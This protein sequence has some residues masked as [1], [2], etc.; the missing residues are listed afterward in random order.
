[1]TMVNPSRSERGAVPDRPDH[2]LLL[3]IQ[4]FTV[5]LSLMRYPSAVP[6]IPQLNSFALEGKLDQSLGSIVRA[7]A[8]EGLSHPCHQDFTQLDRCNNATC[9]DH[10]GE[11]VDARRARILLQEEVRSSP[12]G[13]GGLRRRF[14]LP[15]TLPEPVT[16]PV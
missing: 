2:A 15:Q 1:M 11:N 10:H 13:L 5:T 9:D 3:Q 7:I 4:G 6:A 16:P 12:P 8:S 14:L